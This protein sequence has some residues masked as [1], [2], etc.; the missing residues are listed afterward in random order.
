MP[1][2]SAKQKVALDTLMRDEAYRHA[3]AIIES[4]GLH[5]LT[6]ERL[7]KR[8]GVSR[9]SLY[10][11]FADR[12]AVVDLVEERTF[13]P[14]IAGLETIADGGESAAAKLEAI[15]G[16]ILAAVRE[17]RTVVAALSP[18]KYSG[19]DK[20]SHIRRRERG[21]N[22][23]RRVVQEGIDDGEF[24]K[25]PANLVAEVLYAT[26]TG[27]IDDMAQR[28]AFQKPKAIVPTLMRVFLQG[29]KRGQ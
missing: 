17:N 13:E 16:T 29:L 25:L 23:L 12:D 19:R 24:R 6:L 4:H 15:T 28:G 21:L 18:E 2:Y 5:G 8:I 10:N 9:G 7:A 14:M 20:Q 22:L 27:L 11:Y 1:R 26:I 3:V